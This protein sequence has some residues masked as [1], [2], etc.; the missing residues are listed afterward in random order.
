[1]TS[2]AV[3]IYRCARAADCE[4]RAFVLT[5]V[6]VDNEILQTATHYVL[7]VDPLAA[8]AARTHLERYEQESR[9]ARPRQIPRRA[10]HPDA[11]VGCL[12]YTAVL[13]FIAYAVRS[14]L[15]PL[16]AFAAGELHAAAVQ[17]GEWWRA[18]TALT[19]HFGPGHLAANLAAGIWFGYLA[20]R[21][22]GPGTAWALIVNGGAVA[23]L[24][25]GL[26]A[27]GP[28]RSAG[29]ST[30]VFTALGL[31]AAYA[32][33]ERRSMREH[34]ALDLSPLVAGVVLLGWLG[35]AGRHTDVFAHLMGFLVGVLLGTAIAAPGL[36]RSLEQLPQWVS[37][38]FALGPIVLAWLLAVRG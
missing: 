1:M 28:H 19:L 31:L 27:A 33:R 35:T 17:H 20:G 4:E 10:P 15:G 9:R 6:G 22:F 25:E 32:W 29:A 24:I 18:W 3:E 7:L 13:V 36:Q 26:L 30:A 2:E 5:A 21:Q 38:A 23:N 37:G 8:E 14:G 16:D 12:L 34:W 11:W